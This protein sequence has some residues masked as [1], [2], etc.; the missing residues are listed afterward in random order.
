MHLYVYAVIAAILFLTGYL[1]SQIEN[2]YDADS[3]RIATVLLGAAIA[4]LFVLG[5]ALFT[6]QKTFDKIDRSECEFAQT[7]ETLF[8][9]CRGFETQTTNHF[10]YENHK[11]TSKVG[12]YKVTLENDAL[13]ETGHYLGIKRK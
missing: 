3:K 12:I 4:V 2:G 9:E 6:E 10:I 13:G 5:T 8:V 1:L 7:S 11:D